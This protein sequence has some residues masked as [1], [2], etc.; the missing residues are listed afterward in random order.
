M[1][2]LQG[3]VHQPHGV[4]RKSQSALKARG[5][6]ACGQCPTCDTIAAAAPTQPG[7]IENRAPRLYG[8]STLV[9]SLGSAVSGAS[10]SGFSSCPGSPPRMFWLRRQN[11]ATWRPNY[12]PS[13]YVPCPHGKFE[14]ACSALTG[15][16]LLP[17]YSQRTPTRP[18]S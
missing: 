11:P 6:M 10:T 4:S 2:T 12:D 1:R 13:R 8:T 5:L 14:L 3:P 15:S 9:R 17:S 16:R 7:T 18:Y